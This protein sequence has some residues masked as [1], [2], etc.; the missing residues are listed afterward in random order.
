LTAKPDRAV[1]KLQMATPKA[2]SRGRDLRS[3][4]APN[5]GATTVYTIKKAD[6]KLPRLASVSPIPDCFRLSATAA[7]MYRSR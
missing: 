1:A 2:I 6:M 7:T 3:P 4:K 5:M